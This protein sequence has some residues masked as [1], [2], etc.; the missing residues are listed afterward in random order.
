MVFKGREAKLN[1]AILR[2]M[3]DSAP[4]TKYEIHKQITKIWQL[5]KTRYSNVNTRIRALQE[6]GFLK[7]AGSRETKAG[8]E[9][10]L[11]EATAKAILNL[12]LNGQNLDELIG[13]FNEDEASVIST[14]VAARQR[15]RKTRN[16]A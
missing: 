16:P 7:G 5:R 9:A 15:T 13:D 2:L 8:F 6:E 1:L 10:T 12:Q 3:A 4:L 11:Y 14:L